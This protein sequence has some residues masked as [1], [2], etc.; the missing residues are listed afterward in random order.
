VYCNRSCLCV[1][2]WGGGGG[3]G[4]GGSVTTI[5]QNCL[6]LTKLG[7]WVKVVT[8]YSWSAD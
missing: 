8:I 6:Q 4:G 7:L 3:G 2:V 1:C 5:T